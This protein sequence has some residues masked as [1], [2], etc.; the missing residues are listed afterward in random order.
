MKKNSTL[1]PFVYCIVHGP[2]FCALGKLYSLDCFR[3]CAVMP[4]FVG[5]TLLLKN[6]VF[7]TQILLGIHTFLESSQNA[8]V[9]FRF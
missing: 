8:M 3:T 7:C 5:W 2:D 9:N 1:D 6:A 4:T